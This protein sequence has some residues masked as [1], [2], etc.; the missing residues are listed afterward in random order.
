MRSI[1]Y[2]VGRQNILVENDRI[3]APASEVSMDPDGFVRRSKQ[4]LALNPPEVRT[5]ISPSEKSVI[6][7]F[8]ESPEDPRNAIPIGK[9]VSTEVPVGRVS[10][11]A[12][13]KMLKSVGYDMTELDWRHG[14]LSQCEDYAEGHRATFLARRIAIA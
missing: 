10:R 2:A 1:A 3:F 5:A 8:A 12:L 14:D 9:D 11:S 7:V 13:R 4:N 6:E